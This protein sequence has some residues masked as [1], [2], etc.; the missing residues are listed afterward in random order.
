ML[1]FDFG[2]KFGEPCNGKTI[3]CV[4]RKA[5]YDGRDMRRKSFLDKANS[6][7]RFDFVKQHKREES[8]F[9]NSAIFANE[10]KFTLY[11][12]DENQK[13]WRKTNAQPNQIIG[14]GTIKYKSGSIIIWGLIA[15][16]GVDN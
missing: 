10:S 5:E 11:G 7:R 1:A 9:R 2:N 12:S 16:S 8:K 3:I 14:R 13:V 4:L 15:A 6:N